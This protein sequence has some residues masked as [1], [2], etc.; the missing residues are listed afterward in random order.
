KSFVVM[1]I[2]I[3]NVVI[4]TVGL[5]ILDEQKTITDDQIKLAET[6]ILQAATAIQKAQLFEQ[7]EARAEELAVI[8]EVAQTV[9]QQTDQ[10]ELTKSIQAQIQR[11]MTVD[12][13]FIAIYDAR[14]DLIEY[15]Y[16]YDDGQVYQNPPATPS[17]TSRVWQV[18]QTGQPILVNRSQAEIDELSGQQKETM[19]GDVQR[20]SA[21]LLYIPL[22]SGQDILGV[23]S[24]QSYQLNAYSEANIALLSGIA[25]H[26][27]VA[28][29]NMRLLAETRQSAQ[30]EQLL[31]EI[32]ATIN[33]SIDAESVLQTAAREIGRA[34]GVETFVYL[35]PTINTAKP[36]A[37]SDAKSKQNGNG[38]TL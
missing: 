7:T 3:D 8:N 4:G 2:I 24:L 17:R 22:L 5:D 32:S 11:V 37:N 38:A 36:A 20:I 9:A 31:R 14:H 10:L 12:A 26:V 6:L 13:F 18:L 16:I 15:P 21:S 27:A 23:L 25:N 35:T 1:P 28:L 19:L 34:I 33:T 29:E 30:R